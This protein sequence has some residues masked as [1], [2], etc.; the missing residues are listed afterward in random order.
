MNFDYSSRLILAFCLGAFAGFMWLTASGSEPKEFHL[1]VGFCALLAIACV[2][3][4]RAA[5]FFGSVVG[6]CLIAIGLSGLSLFGGND[7]FSAEYFK[8]SFLVIGIGV[9]LIY[10]F[11]FGFR[12]LTDEVSEED[13][14]D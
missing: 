3:R 4:G 5:G 2:A 11:R 14:Q 9:V 6:L 1:L 12:H 13:E 10:K 7:A 8:K